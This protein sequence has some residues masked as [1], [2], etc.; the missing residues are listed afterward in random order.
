MENIAM[1]VYPLSPT[2]AFLD[3][4]PASCFFTGIDLWLRGHNL[5]CFPLTDGCPEGSR[6]CHGCQKAPNSKEN[7]GRDLHT[8]L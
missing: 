4:S 5:S 3:F 8:L 6:S 1:V 2:Q 7:A